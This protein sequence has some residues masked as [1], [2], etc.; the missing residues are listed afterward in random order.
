MQTRDMVKAQR[1]SIPSSSRSMC[2]VPLHVR[3]GLALMRRVC[4]SCVTPLNLS[5]L[6]DDEVARSTTF[7]ESAFDGICRHPCPPRLF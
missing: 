1:E 5:K 6:L 4:P 7:S 2:F 3:H